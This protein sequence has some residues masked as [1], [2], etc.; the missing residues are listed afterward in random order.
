MARFHL[1]L[2]SCKPGWKLFNGTAV[3]L[4]STTGLNIR[5][6]SSYSR[7]SCTLY[8]CWGHLIL[9]DG[10]IHSWQKKKKLWKWKDSNGQ[11]QFQSLSLVMQNLAANGSSGSEELVSWKRSESGYE[12]QSGVATDLAQWTA[13]GW[14]GCGFTSSSA[15]DSVSWFPRCIAETG[16]VT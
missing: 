16:G 6:S 3:T 11:K 14:G 2:L 12:E 13:H 5:F 7:Y 15:S 10:R 8:V 4:R 9:S 1:K